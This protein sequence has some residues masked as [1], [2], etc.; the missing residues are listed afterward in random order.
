MNERDRYSYEGRRQREARDRFDSNADP[1]IQEEMRH[2]LRQGKAGLIEPLARPIMILAFLVI[3][4]LGYFTF[5]PAISSGVNK[6]IQF[7]IELADQGHWKRAIIEFDEAIRRDPEAADDYNHRGNVYR[8]LSQPERAI[9]DYN[10]AI[11]LDPGF[12]D[13]YKSRAL[14]YTVLGNDVDAE[15]DVELALVL[16]MDPGELELAIEE[17]GKR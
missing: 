15:K 17:L 16:G 8:T 4:S 7:G 3:G 6:H 9:Q 2:V 1:L 5:G 13:A 10:E 12:A 11:R 14:A